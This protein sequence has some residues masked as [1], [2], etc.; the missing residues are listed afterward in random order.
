MSQRFVFLDFLRGFS[1]LAILLFHFN[2][3]Y[4]KVI[5]NF[6]IFVDLFF[7]LSGFVLFPM[8]KKINSGNDFVYFY[9]SRVY[10]LF[11]LAIFVLLTRYLLEIAY[12]ILNND[13]NSSRFEYIFSYNALV[14]ILLAMLLFQVFSI[15][16]LYWFFPLWS[17]SAEW[18]AYQISALLKITFNKLVYVGSGLI[19][20][21]Y[22]LIFYGFLYDQDSIAELGPIF[23]SIGLGRAFAGFGSGLVLRHFAERGMKYNLKNN[24][25]YL[26]MAVSALLILLYQGDNYSIL[27]L[28]IPVFS[29]LIYQGSRLQIYST[30][31]IKIFSL[32]GKLSYSIYLWHTLALS[33]VLNIYSNQNWIQHFVPNIELPLMVFLSLGVIITLFLAALSW[34]YIELPWI[35]KGRRQSSKIGSHHT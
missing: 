35:I 5:E 33:I 2:S 24:N 8:I 3:G 14:H 29:I 27:L 6:Y 18:I 34:K 30:Y 20:I 11:P 16:A 15:G 4:F 32:S 21:G 7:I 28:T 10:R 13:L 19:I 22:G 25:V 9:I 23:G 31:L 17:L 26:F 12:L 1:A